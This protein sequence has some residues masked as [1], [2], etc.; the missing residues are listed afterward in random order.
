[1]T[2]HAGG[3]LCGA[4][5]Y[6]TRAAPLHTTICHCTFCQ[7]LTGSAFLVEPIFREADVTF[8]GA[9]AKTYQRCSEGSG[10]TV[11]L[12]FCAA[13][14]TTLC[15]SFE[16]FPGVLGL[17][18]GTFDDPNWFDRGP[19]KARHIFTRHA[20]KGVVLPPGLKTYLDHATQADGTP[21]TPRVFAE[22]YI[23]TG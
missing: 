10:K 15:L 1:M 11:S 14:G 7:R 6:R 18:G 13:C 23:V 16:R 20:Q 17:C 19:A 22:P 21:N 9:A 12:H 8:S 4:I 2:D 3:C 5:R